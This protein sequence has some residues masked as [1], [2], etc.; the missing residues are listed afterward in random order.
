M[1]NVIPRKPKGRRRPK[2]TGLAL[3]GRCHYGCLSPRA[4]DRRGGPSDPSMLWYLERT[5]S[6]TESIWALTLT[7]G[8][9]GFLHTLLGPDHYIP[10]IAMGQAGRWSRART[11]WIA[12]L[13]GLGHVLSSVL[14]GAVGIAV[15]L[16]LSGME[17][18]EA[19]RGDMAAWAL[20]AVGGAYGAWG[21]RRAMKGR[22][23]THTHLHGSGRE[24]GHSHNHQTE[25]AHVHGA[26]E[27]PRLTPWVLFTVFVLGPCEPLIPIL[28][29]PAAQ[30]SVAGV[31]WVTAVF[32]AV[33]LATMLTVVFLGT[34]G[35][36]RLPMGRL[37]R[38]TH[39]LAGGALCLCGAA[40]VLGL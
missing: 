26:A 16:A 21:L 38:Y 19:V 3:G 37:E 9:I 2:Q 15:G 32:G 36:D 30:Q 14:L 17:T 13:C 35:I 28:M 22:T 39:A 11:L 31:V 27:G 29:V 20:I 33:T 10:F 6:L 7:A 5:H 1:G 25:H 34:L 40:M 23:H 4:V 8:S 24:H 12:G 18:V